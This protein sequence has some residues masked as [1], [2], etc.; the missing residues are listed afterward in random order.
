MAVDLPPDLVRSL[1]ARSGADRWGLG[2]DQFAIALSAGADRLFAGRQ[3]SR[4]ELERGL[5]ALHL[6][7]LALAGACAEGSPAAWE[8]VMV[9]HRPALYRMADALDPAGGARELADGIWADLYGI[10]S[11]GAERRSLFRHFHGRSSLSTWLRSV[12]AQR[13]IDRFRARRRE[14]AL[15]DDDSPAAIP[16]PSG[17]PD[18][19]R[20]R[21]VARLHK[22][23]TDALAELSPRER[24]RLRC[25]YA[26]DLTLA[27]TGR[28]TGEHEATVSRQLARTRRALRVN[29][30][31]RLRRYDRLDERQI[32]ECFAAV[33][34]DAGPLDLLELLGERDPRKKPA[35]DRSEEG[36]SGE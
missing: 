3:P 6:D 15:P 25:Y 10:R 17:P 24:L 8:H 19:E 22:A 31:E 1:H 21:H 7:D 33:T 18:P 23:L 26:E 14:R 36:P 9:T 28:V 4:L 5:L 13:H 35:D 29:V 20:A 34:A 32:G 30:Q 12:L 27:Q 16:A 2:P 11:A